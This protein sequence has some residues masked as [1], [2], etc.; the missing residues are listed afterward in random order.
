M[1]LRILYILLWCSM[2][3]SVSAQTPDTAVVRKQMPSNSLKKAASKLS[4]SLGEDKTD[5]QIAADYETLA[6]ELAGKGEYAKAEEYLQ[7]ARDIY[8]RLGNKRKLAAVNRESAKLREQ[9]QDFAGAVK[10]YEEAVRASDNRGDRQLNLNDADRL[11]NRSN[12]EAQSKLIESNIQLLDEKQA[13][14][15]EKSAAYR[16]LAETNLQMKQSEAAIDNYEKALSNVSDKQ[17]EVV[18]I[19]KEMSKVYIAE[20]QYDKALDINMEVVQKAREMKDVK[21]EIGGLQSLSHIYFIDDRADKGMETLMQAYNLAIEEGQTFEA[22]RSLELLADQYRKNGNST[23]QLE[24]Y[25]NFSDNLERVIRADSSLVDAKLF[26]VT[27]GRIKQLEKERALKDELIQRTNRFNYVLIASIVLML[28]LS[29]LIVKAWHTVRVRNKKIALQSL[30]REMNPHFVFNS[31]NSVNQFIAGNNELAAN[32]YLTSYSKLMRNV[33]ENSSKDF[34]KLSAEIEQLKEYLDLEHLRFSDKFTYEIAVDEHIDAEAV[35]IPNMLIQTHLENAI[36]H[37]LRYRK[38]KGL[39][40]LNFAAENGN[41][42]VTV[43]D[44]GI[45][46]RQSESIKTENQKAHHRSR[47]L[48]N[49]TERIKLLNELY[50]TDIRLTIKEKES[51]ETGVAVR[52]TINNQRPT[53]T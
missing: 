42:I 33:M 5:E 51:P 17:S 45:G 34:V 11:R 20:K 7:R 50:K 36:W 13:P 24:L 2:C 32:K 37:G 21:T 52:L 29:A 18:E 6:G 12:P 28:L 35:Y 23:K 43:D 9:Q 31:L 27:E 48:T 14:R 4:K 1:I 8:T 25:R 16:Q 39:L 10:Y 41:I 26:Q 53:T 19:K 40:K 38:D 30:R 49:I 44:N 46:L 47:G 22:K 15:E 3:C